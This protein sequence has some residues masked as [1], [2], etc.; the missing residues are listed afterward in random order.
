MFFYYH[1]KRS[2]KI[3][4]VYFGIQ[5]QGHFSIA[6][7]VPLFC[8]EECQLHYKCKLLKVFCQVDEQ[9][10]WTLF[11]FFQMLGIK[12][13]KREFKYFESLPKNKQG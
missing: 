7:V 3:D 12:L 11:F 8:V 6:V 2:L 4:V 5:R 9:E 1:S 13:Y 10:M